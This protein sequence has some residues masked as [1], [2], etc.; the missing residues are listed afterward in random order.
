MIPLVYRSIEGFTDGKL[1]E[2]FNECPINTRM[3]NQER[4]G[5]LEFNDF[6]CPRFDA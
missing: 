1:I 5:I 3:M 4:V 6:I 2:I